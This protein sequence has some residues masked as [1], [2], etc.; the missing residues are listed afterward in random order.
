MARQKEPAETNLGSG[1]VPRQAALTPH[2]GPRQLRAAA[3]GLKCSPLFP[4][5][6]PPRTVVGCCWPG[7]ASE[8]S[9]AGSCCLLAS[10]GLAH[11]LASGKVCSGP[12]TGVHLP[13]SERQ[14]FTEASEALSTTPHPLPPPS[15]LALVPYPPL[16]AMPASLQFPEHTKHKPLPGQLFPYKIQSP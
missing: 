9:R 7:G 12:E 3:P 2:L 5:S 4:L 8:C 14:V 13:R 16:Q 15:P 6:A 1:H 10:G 11:G